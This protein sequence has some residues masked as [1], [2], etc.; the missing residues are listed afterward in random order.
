V[1]KVFS[2]S[3]LRRFTEDDGGSGIDQ[4]VDSLGNRRAGSQSRRRIGFAAF[5]AD[6]QILKFHWF[7]SQFGSPLD[8]FL[9]FPRRAPHCFKIPVTFNRKV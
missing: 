2:A 4:A 6:G 5:D 8:V 1:A 7:S 3:Q 9:R